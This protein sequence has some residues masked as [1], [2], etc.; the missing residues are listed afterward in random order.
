M[1]CCIVLSCA[2]LCCALYTRMSAS[3]Y[4]AMQILDECH[5]CVKDA[6]YNHIMHIY[7]SLSEEDQ[8]K[9]QVICH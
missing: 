6:P 5:H 3:A 9:T 7:K 2:V 8:A 1:L 4:V